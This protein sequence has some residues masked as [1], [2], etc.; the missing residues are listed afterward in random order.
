MADLPDSNGD[1]SEIESVKQTARDD[2]ETIKD[3]AREDLEAVKDQ[4]KAD[5][6]SVR[7]EAGTYIDGQKNY[8]AHQLSGIAEA[9][10]R[11]GKEMHTGENAWA[12]RY[13]DD[14]AHRLEEVADR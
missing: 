4:A 3:H 11:V 10:G 8:A 7:H 2:F 1:G 13:A 12:S 14:I 5:F 6:E 9:I